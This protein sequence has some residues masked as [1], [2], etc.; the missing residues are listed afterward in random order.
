MSEPGVEIRRKVG[1]GLFEIIPN[2][3]SLPDASSVEYVGLDVGG[4]NI[5]GTPAL[6]ENNATVLRNNHGVFIILGTSSNRQAVQESLVLLPLEKQTGNGLASA[7]C[8]SNEMDA[9]DVAFI[10]IEDGTVRADGLQPVIIWGG[11]SPY[12]LSSKDSKGRRLQ[13]SRETP[14]EGPVTYVSGSGNS[15]R[16]EAKYAPPN[17]AEKPFLI[18]EKTDI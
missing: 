1:P 17:V 16:I 3:Y 10:P 14:S 13:H 9:V 11:R 8:L 15:V 12:T 7:L 6:V 5:R 18:A 2:P 4:L